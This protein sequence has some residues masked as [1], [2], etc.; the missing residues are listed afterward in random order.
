[1]QPS[2]TRGE[3]SNK[4][5]KHSETILGRVHQTL[6]AAAGGDDPLRESLR[7]GRI[8]E[9]LSPAGFGD[10]AGLKLIPAEQPP[11]CAH[12]AAKAGTAE[13]EPART[14]EPARTHQAQAREV[15]SQP[16]RVR[17]LGR[18]P[19]ESAS[20][21]R[22]R[23]QAEE[24]SRRDALRQSRGVARRE[25]ERREQEV[26][27]AESEHTRLEKL[28]LAAEERARAA[29]QEVDAAARALESARA[30]L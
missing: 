28:A 29:W 12:E 26:D 5:A 25:F 4:P 30:T 10:L 19:V 18:G 1:M 7:R 8:E 21:P 27:R 13:P 16:A 17:E 2:H 24:K 23:E 9:D 15:K 3:C 20:A 11:P 6:L 14:R 22:R